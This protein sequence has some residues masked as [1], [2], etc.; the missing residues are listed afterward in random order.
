MTRNRYWIFALM[1]LCVCACRQMPVHDVPRGMVLKTFSCTADNAKTSLQSDLSVRWN[2]SDRIT[3]FAENGGT[4]TLDQSGLSEDGTV[5]W[6]SGLVPETG[7]LY[8]VYPAQ[9][10]SSFDGTVLHMEVPAGQQ[11]VAD[12]MADGAALA[13]AL[14]DG[15]DQLAF[16]NVCGLLAFT[17]T[18]TDIQSMTLRAAEAAGGALSG[19]GTVSYAEDMP[20]GKGTGQ[21]SLLTLTGG[22]E[23]GSTYYLAAWPGSYRQLQLTFTDTHGRT[24]VFDKDAVLTVERS[25]LV[26]ISPITVAESDWTGASE[27]KWELLADIGDLAEDDLV[28]IASR[29]KDVVA[30]DIDNA[31]MKPLAASFSEDKTEI[32]QLPED[33][34]VLTMR[35]EGTAWRMENAGGQYLGATTV[36][37]LSWTAGTATW[38]ISLDASGNTTVT[39]TM[40]G[41]GTLRYNDSSPRFTTY[42]SSTGKPVQLYRNTAGVRTSYV[43]TLPA[44]GVTKSTARLAGLYRSVTTT[45]SALWFR[46]GTASTALTTQLAADAIPSGDKAEFGASLSGLPAS[47]TYYYQA[48]A[49]IDGVTYEGDVLSFT[50]SADSG[51]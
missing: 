2:A 5:A 41:Y 37:K 17:V 10:G 8:A 14:L 45:P 15:S 21:E 35:R 16:R 26:R 23:S 4:Y 39:N 32:T 31:V 1:L 47:T 38:N 25:A 6:F 19:P 7:C 42:T 43:N 40:S 18:G 49:T 29:D 22:L 50:T 30:G 3:V 20:V 34:I 44:T 24:A 12:G 9:E 13:V 46:Y 48:F 36:K 27:E 11:A 33:A 28:V 51:T